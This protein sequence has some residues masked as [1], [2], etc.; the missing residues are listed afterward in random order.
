[1]NEHAKEIWQVALDGET[2][3]Y[4]TGGFDHEWVDMDPFECN[5]Y[6]QPQQIPDRWRIKPEKK[7]RYYRVYLVEETDVVRVTETLNS[8]GTPATAEFVK[9]PERPFR[10]LSEWMTYEVEV[11]E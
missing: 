11:K 4:L 1:M 10:W 3:Q 5:Y 2:V 9:N 8:D 7:T 6:S